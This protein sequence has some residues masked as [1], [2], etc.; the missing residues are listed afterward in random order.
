M[1]AY[2]SYNQIKMYPSDEDKTAF[3]TGGSKG[4]LL[5]YLI[6]FFRDVMNK[7]V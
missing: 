6:L 5:D 2:S 7:I 1:D 4:A 3:I